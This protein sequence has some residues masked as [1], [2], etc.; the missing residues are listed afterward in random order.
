VIERLLPSEVAYV[1]AFGDLP[2]VKLFPEEETLIARAVGKRRREFTTA[3]SCA[4][5]ALAA[6][7]VAPMPILPGERG[8]PQWPPGFVGSITHCAGYRAAAVARSRD[9]LTIG[10]D[11][12]PD[13]VLS[14][15]ILEAVSL[16]GERDRLRDL[17]AVAPNT[18]W[19]RLLFSAK[20]SVYK[21]WFP[22][23]RRWLDFEDAD[24]VINAS[25]GTFAV[26]LLVDAPTISGFPLVSFGGRWLACD[27]LILTAVTVPIGGSR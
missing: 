11:A 13:G 5:S 1:E 4:R 10:V 26:Q 15:G 9:V 3:R 20:E 23:A 27:G 19:D 7:G 2:D 17:A 21:A 22:L 24:I 12:E 14:D 25:D 6:L 16:P 18:C 8:A